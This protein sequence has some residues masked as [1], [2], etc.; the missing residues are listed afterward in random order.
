MKNI[1]SL[2]AMVGLLSL[3]ACG[4]SAQKE[5]TKTQTEEVNSADLVRIELK[6]EGMTCTGCEN[7]IKTKIAELGDIKSVEASHVDGV[8]KV[9]LPEGAV[10]TED[11]KK[12][13]AAAGYTVNE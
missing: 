1:F 10:S 6:V 7:T 11:I 9:E 12:A 13:I 2:I 8:V 3:A 5:A 4:G